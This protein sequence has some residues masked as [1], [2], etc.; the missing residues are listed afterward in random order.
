MKL[1]LQLILII[2]CIGFLSAD[3][4]LSQDKE[5]IKI[6]CLFD[7]SGPAGHI[8]TPSKHVAEMAVER[9]NM[10]GGVN[11]R[12]IQLIYGDSESD[13]G[14]AA[15]EAKRLIE[16]DKVTAII[17]PT[18]TGSAMAILNIADN[19]Q[20]P[21]VACVGG[22]PPVE[23]VR[24][25]VFKSPQKTVTAVEKVYQYLQKHG[26][27]KVAI[28]TASDSFG[29]EGEKSLYALAGKYGI[30]IAASEKFD[31][32]DSDMTVQ[33][34]KLKNVGE[35]A[36][37]CWTIGPP[38][39]IVA[40]NVKQLD[41]K[42]PIIQCHGLP[43]PKFI[44]LAGVAAEGNIMPS[45]RLMVPDQL[46][47]SDPQ[48]KLII[49][50][51]NEYENVKKYGKVST[52]SGYAWD[53]IM[54]LVNAMRTAGTTD[55]AKVRD[56]IENTKEYVGISGI[57]NMSPTDHCGLAVDSMVMITVKDGKWKLIE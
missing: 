43:D 13:A 42:I 14:K 35:Q 5:P 10:E 7:L 8:G 20:I 51:I 25:W 31:I 46:S 30:T 21:V 1:G 32:K 39:S 33:L 22:T 28:I 55:P 26:I 17:G 15:Q 57:Y 53:A 24:K 18:N 38:G 29:K 54:L 44:E 23:P 50:F 19:A 9:I 41:Y 12:P 37:I 3:V 11:G 34:T 52:H 45:T 49:E 16:K 48:K 6:G 2:L 56:A 47:D 4:C 27:K 36:L 40:K